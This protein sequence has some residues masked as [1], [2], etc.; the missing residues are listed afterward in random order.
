MTR[1][2]PIG[3]LDQVGVAFLDEGTAHGCCV[4]L[5]VVVGGRAR[6]R[7]CGAWL[8]CGSAAVAETGHVLVLACEQ[9]FSSPRLRGEVD[10]RAERRKSGEGAFPRFC[11]WRLGPP[12]PTLS[13]P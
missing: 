1:H 13:P 10:L 4:F 12:P 3:Q 11:V 8:L 6:G 5:A 9:I 2:R 7:G